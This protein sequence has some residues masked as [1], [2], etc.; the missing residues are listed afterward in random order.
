[1]DNLTHTLTGLLMAR[2]GLN[3]F[4]PRAAAVLLLAAN[5]P[6]L[7]VVT[8][9]G[10][11]ST[12][13]ALHRHVTHSLAMAPLLALLPVAIVRLARRSGLDWTR[14]WLVSLAGVLSHLLLDLTNLYGIRLLLPF[15][16]SW[17]R[18][19]IT[20][21]VDAWIWA[22]LILAVA[23]PALSRLVES[24][25]GEAGRN[26]RHGSRWA[27]FAL[28]FVLVYNGA[29]A[30]LHDRAVAILE[31]RI[32]EGSP[33]Q[34]VAAFPD[35]VN[36]LRWRGL[37]EGE[38]FYRILDVDLRSEFD[39]SRG[40]LFYKG[41]RNAAVET[42]GQT[43]PFRSLLGFVQYPLWVVTPE[44]ESALRVDLMDLRFG[45]PR[46]PGFTAT[47]RVDGRGRVLESAFRF[48]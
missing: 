14:C 31:S 29:R 8:A 23:A 44:P 10:G 21:V 39:P 36:P 20:S 9:L 17:L 40:T 4:T 46:Q 18:L 7:D 11:S 24:E 2:A 3:R 6:D 42:A 16:G 38:A 19:D 41:E 34:R 26:R 32:Y 25:I 22:A 28:A 30:L 48:R 1:M 33:A 27:L 15:S 45:T 13:L 43:E 5:A 47:A 35:P 12:Y 37:V